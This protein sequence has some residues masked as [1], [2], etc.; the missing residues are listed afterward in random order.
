MKYA[1]QVFHSNILLEE[2]DAKKTIDIGG[3]VDLL[4]PDKYQTKLNQG[5]VLDKGPT[6][7]ES[8]QTGS[9]LFFGLHAE[10]RLD[11]RGKKYIVVD[12]SQVLG[13]IQEMP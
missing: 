2:I 5:R 8:I 9:I 11:Y 3:G 6:V 1:L 7:S 13:A 4:V 12:E 10:H